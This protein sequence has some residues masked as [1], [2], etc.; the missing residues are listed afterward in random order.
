MMLLETYPRSIQFNV[1]HY[2]C[3]DKQRNQ[4]ISSQKNHLFTNWIMNSHH[5]TKDDLFLNITDA[6][7]V[8]IHSKS[9]QSYCL[10]L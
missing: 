4:K 2:T 10:T 6:L 5:R 3:F 9:T 8:F 1:N 7:E